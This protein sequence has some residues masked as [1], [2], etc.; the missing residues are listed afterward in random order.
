MTKDMQA[1]SDVQ[2]A[3][4]DDDVARLLQRVKPGGRALSLSDDRGTLQVL[5]AQADQV[6][7]CQLMPEAGRSI[8]TELPN[9][10]YVDGLAETLPWPDDTLDLVCCINTAHRFPD[11]DRCLEEAA[12]V[13]APGGSLVIFDRLLPEDDRPAR[14]VNAF[15]GLGDLHHHRAFA[16]YQWHGMC[17]NAGLEVIH[18]EVCCKRTRLLAWSE[19]H[20]CTGEV[21][22]RLQILLAQAPQ[23]VS[24]F[25]HPSC[26]ATPDAEFD[27]YFIG[28]VGGKR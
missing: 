24:E 27:Q 4:R 28:L 15:Y 17:L 1:H 8:E 18:S 11:V 3:C 2:P 25:L 20:G 13:L 10:T 26:A 7:V 21:I 12:R 14:Y 23:A 16:E 22:E 6:L 19:A 5:A 9:V